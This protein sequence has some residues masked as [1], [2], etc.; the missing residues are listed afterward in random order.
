[1]AT[2]TSSVKPDGSIYGEGHGAYLSN[3][4]D[5]VTWKG[6]GVGTLAANGTATY[7]GAIYYSTVSPK[8]ARLNT[9][10]GVFEFSAD[11]Q[12]NTIGKTW[13]WK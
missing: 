4:G 8:F 10:A 7:R 9:V 1:M 5:V 3:S 12:G 11:A 2:Y 6:S 13:E